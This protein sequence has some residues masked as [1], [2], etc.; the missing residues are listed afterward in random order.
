MYPKSVWMLRHLHRHQ[1]TTHCWVCKCRGSV[2]LRRSW[3]RWG[4]WR[5]RRQLGG[6]R[7]HLHPRLQL[8]HCRCWL[9]GFELALYLLVA[10]W[11]CRLLGEVLWSKAE[12]QNNLLLLSKSFMPPSK[13]A[14]A[15][16]VLAAERALVPLEA[17]NVVWRA[18]FVARASRTAALAPSAAEATRNTVLKSMMNIAM[19]MF[20]VHELKCCDG[21]MKWRDR[22]TIARLYTKPARN[23]STE[24][25]R[26]DGK[27]SLHYKF[28]SMMHRGLLGDK[29][30]II[31]GLRET[32][33]NVP[34]HSHNRINWL[35]WFQ[36]SFCSRNAW[37]REGERKYL[38]H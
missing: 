7:L 23:P 1:S 17:G 5:E 16:I 19:N 14:P 13:V 37:S 8:V 34:F 25:W 18:V 31:T 9:K 29:L 4:R 35:E 6:R 30:S 21:Q 27:D 10:P 28:A 33:T 3:A 20:K 22:R 36:P 11:Y 2:R 32:R 12:E 15:A 24:N 26:Q 38:A